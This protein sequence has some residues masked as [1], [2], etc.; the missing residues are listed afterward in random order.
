MA[1][2]LASEVIAAAKEEG[3]AFK[4]KTDT[5]KMAKLTKHFHTLNSNLKWQEILNTQEI[6]VLLLTLMQVKLPLQKVFY[7][8]QGK[9]QNW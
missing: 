3:A 1:Q 2:K 9:P 4:K 5:H 8:I 6:L 7:S